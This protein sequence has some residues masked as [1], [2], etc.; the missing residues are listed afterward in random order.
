MAIAYDSSAKSSGSSVSSLT[1]SHTTSG[2][3][4][5]LF[6]S[7]AYSDGG[8]RNISSV[9]YNGVGMTSIYEYTNSGG[10]GGLGLFYLIAPAT[11]AHNVVI[12]MSSSTLNLYGESSSYTGANQYLQP[13]AFNFNK[14][15]GSSGATTNVTTVADNCWTVAGCY[16]FGSNSGTISSAQ[17]GRQG[18]NYSLIADSN[19][20]KTPAGAVTMNY[21]ETGMSTN[22][23]IAASFSPATVLA[24]DSSSGGAGSTSTLTFSHTCS[25]TN[26]LL[27][28]SVTVPQASSVTSVTYNGVSMTGITSQN[29]PL[30]LR[31]YLYY[32]INPTSGA[33]N[34]VVTLNGSNFKSANSVS[35]TGA[36][37]YLQPDAFNSAASYTVNNTVIGSSCWIVSTIGTEGT[38]TAGGSYVV[39]GGQVSGGYYNYLEDSNAIISSGSNTVTFTG[40]PTGRDA[41]IAASINSAS[42]TLYWVGGTGNFDTSTATHWSLS[43]GG[44][45][46]QGL[47]DSSSTCIFDAN[48]GGGTVTVSTTVSIYS[49]TTTGY[50][51]TF[52]Q[53]NP[54]TVGNTLTVGSHTYNVNATL[55]VGGNLTMGTT[56]TLAGSSAMSV[57]GNLTL[58]SGMTLSYTGAIT[59]TSTITGRTITTATKTI[60]SPIVFNSVGGSWILQ[61]N[62]TSST[63]I[64]VTNGTLD[65][66][67]KTVSATTVSNAGTITTGNGNQSFTTFTNTGILTLGSGTLTLTGTGT[68]WTGGGTITVGTSTI[69]IT[70]AS[71]TGKIFAGAGLTYNN[72]W[73]TGTGTG[74]FT[75]TGS[76]TFNDFKCDTPPHTI[77]FTAGTTTSIQT[78]TVNGTTGNLMT[79]HSTVD[80][81]QWKLFKTTTGVVSCDYLS[82]KDSFAESI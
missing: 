64:T 7:V 66:N 33:N 38:W 67:A 65:L 17:T 80:G 35:Y 2:T 14:T 12:T 55:T 3:N 15:I 69:K 26:R 78:F 63:S 30:D 29:A 8:S 70:D 22:Y 43:S 68:V 48:S 28:V 34:V 36:N 21:T 49:I 41:I 47:P 73:L 76:N 50:T 18:N 54:L 56:T 1:Y 53:S 51:G 46:G 77:L 32:L 24:Y 59:F 44:T 23:I 39:R 20:A 37:Q 27:L 19:S 6:V 57:G 62:F 52:T 25:G 71:S 45:G 31:A 40:T 5:I 75:I 9:T 42:S 60:G 79:L 61:D 4:R 11:G 81:T 13:D 58:T 72:L 16:A 74:T 10:S 82:L